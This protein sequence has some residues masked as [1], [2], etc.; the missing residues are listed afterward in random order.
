MNDYNIEF[1][2]IYADQQL[3][4]EQIASCFWHDMIRKC[5]KGKKL[6]STILI[7]DYNA[8]NK[9]DIGLLLKNLKKRRIPVD[10]IAFERRLAKTA[11]KLI[12]SIQK[13]RLEL[14]KNRIFLKTKRKI[15]LK[16]DGWYSC[17][18]LISCWIL[19][20][21][22]VYKIPLV[23]VRRNDFVAKKLI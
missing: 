15:L 16:K 21:F 7:D 12:Q 14:K 23:K 11:D 9:L 19:V 2:H 8:E 18:L 5:L 22:G 13:S 17:S 3:S 1:C 4:D 6:S 10:F 20:R